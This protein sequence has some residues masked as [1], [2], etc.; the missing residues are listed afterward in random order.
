MPKSG[1]L[2]IPFDNTVKALLSIIVV[3]GAA[4]FGLTTYY[5]VDLKSDTTALKLSFQNQHDILNEYGTNI[6]DLK[7][8]V[9]I[10]KES[11][12]GVNTANASR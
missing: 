5:F 3:I 10:I 1:Q 7:D 6:K 4:A 11:R 8:D 9:K 12:F 2:I